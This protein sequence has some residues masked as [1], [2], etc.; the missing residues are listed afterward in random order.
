MTNRRRRA[1]RPSELSQVTARY[2]TLIG[3]GAAIAASAVVS[4]WIFVETLRLCFGH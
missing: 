3:C 2:I 4:V 1:W